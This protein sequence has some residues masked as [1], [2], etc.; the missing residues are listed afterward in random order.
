MHTYVPLSGL[1]AEPY[2]AKIQVKAS[3]LG[4]KRASCDEPATS[5]SFAASY[6][7]GTNCSDVLLPPQATSGL[8]LCCSGSP[9]CSPY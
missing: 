2:C 7:L 4:P 1:G 5:P 3:H 8:S 9:V 6:C